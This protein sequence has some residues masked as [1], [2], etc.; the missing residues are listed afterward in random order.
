MPRVFRARSWRRTHWSAFTHRFDRARISSTARKRQTGSRTKS[1]SRVP[2]GNPVPRFDNALVVEGRRSAVWASVDRFDAIVVTDEHDEGLKEE[3]VPAWHARDVAIERSRRAGVPCVLASPCPSLEALAA[4]DHLV[5]PSR[6]DERAGWPIHAFD[7][8]HF[9][10]LVDPAAVT[11][12][13]VML[14][15][16]A[17]QHP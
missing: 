4:A 14:Y 12:A 1:S 5:E 9:H 11:D 3:R 10:M 16:A 2:P 15:E 7:A 6:A 13:L 8:G 17:T